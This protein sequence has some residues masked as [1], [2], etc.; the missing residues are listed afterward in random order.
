[1]QTPH[2][3]K[4]F[5]WSQDRKYYYSAIE[6]KPRQNHHVIHFGRFA[7]DN[8]IARFEESQSFDIKYEYDVTVDEMFLISDEVVLA[9]CPSSYQMVDVRSSQI[10]GVKPFSMFE[11][12]LSCPASKKTQIVLNVAEEGAGGKHPLIQ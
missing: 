7:I 10:D 5:T 1:M 11:Y 8:G 4:V 9:L 2:F 12:R 3:Q 6:S